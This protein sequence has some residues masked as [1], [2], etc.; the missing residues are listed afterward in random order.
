MTDEQ[1]SKLGLVIALIGIVIMA[2]GFLI[3]IY[4]AHR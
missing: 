2:A 4:Q 1:L 3:L